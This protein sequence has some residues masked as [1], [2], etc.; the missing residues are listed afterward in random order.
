[1]DKKVL[2]AAWRLVG[3]DEEGI[4]KSETVIR[5]AKA[6]VLPQ[7]KALPYLMPFQKVMCSSVHADVGVITE[8]LCL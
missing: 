1:M 8:K 7:T 5:V 2:L 6:S 4:D 3:V